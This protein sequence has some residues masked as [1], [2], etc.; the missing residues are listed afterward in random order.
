ML[1]IMHRRG[2]VHEGN[3]LPI[4]AFANF[5]SKREQLTL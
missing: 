3:A 1:V 4:I 2:G 5:S